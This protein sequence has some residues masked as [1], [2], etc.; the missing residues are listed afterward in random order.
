MLRVQE[1]GGFGTLWD[2]LGHFGTP[3][4]ALACLIFLLFL[5][6]RLLV[7]AVLSLS[8]FQQQDTNTE[9]AAARA[10]HPDWPHPTT[11]LGG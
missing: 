7:L 3:W 4:D 6:K 11:R 9:L 1:A 2:T 8:F 10:R 5:G